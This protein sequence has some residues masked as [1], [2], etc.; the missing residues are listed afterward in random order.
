[1]RQEIKRIRVRDIVVLGKRRRLN[2]RKCK[3]ITESIGAIGLRTPITV[4]IRKNGKIV[5][6][7]RSSPA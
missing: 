5:S 4:Y 6:R 7:R 1:M 3:L 2:R